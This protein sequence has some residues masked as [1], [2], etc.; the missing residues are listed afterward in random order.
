MRSVHLYLLGLSLPFAAFA[1]E[2]IQ[3]R[4]TY[5]QAYG[6]TKGAT[7]VDPARDLPRYPAVEPK[8]AIAK[9]GRAHV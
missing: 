7:D 1:A 8:D 6:E 3:H 9:I 2:K 4:N 5:A